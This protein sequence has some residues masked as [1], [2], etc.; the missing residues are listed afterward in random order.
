MPVF[1]LVHVRM[2]MDMIKAV[3][4]VAD[5]VGETRSNIIRRSVKEFVDIQNKRMGGEKLI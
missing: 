3:D 4:C 2:R 1:Q 5:D